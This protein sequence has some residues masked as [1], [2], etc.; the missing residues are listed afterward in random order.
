MKVSVVVATYNGE[1]HLEQQLDSILKQTALPDECVVSDDGSTDQTITIL[2]RFAEEAPFP[3]V[4]LMRQAP[5]GFAHNFASACLK[6]SGDVVILSDQDDSWAPEKIQE[7]MAYFLENTEKELLIH[8]ISI[9]D[10]ELQPTIRS[11]FSYLESQGHDPNYLVKGCATAIRQSL[12][13]RAYPLP[14]AGRWTHDCRLH[15]LASMSGTRGIIRKVL[16]RY[17]VHGSN[18]SGYVLPRNNWKGAISARLKKKTLD[19]ASLAYRVLQYS[20]LRDMSE[21]ELREFYL[22]HCKA[23][24]DVIRGSGQ[25]ST[26]EFDE[27]RMAND[28][29]NYRGQVARFESRLN[30]FVSYISYATRG[31]YSVAGGAYALLG[32]LAA[33][34]RSAKRRSG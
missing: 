15:A 22:A 2:R 19:H 25:V 6:A 17:R 29:L 16:C 4:L 34:F 23:R 26:A 33:V 8:D 18:T 12:L 21:L 1:R 9:C 28:C 14:L 20:S 7:I 10:G 27:L 30:R 24:G 5:L 11:Y 31:G 32:D 13:R 3:V